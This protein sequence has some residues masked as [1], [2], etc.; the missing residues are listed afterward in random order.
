MRRTG[1]DFRVDLR[2]TIKATMCPEIN[3]CENYGPVPKTEPMPFIN[4][5]VSKLR[6]D[7]GESVMERR[8]GEAGRV[9]LM[10]AP[11]LDPKPSLSKHYVA[12]HASSRLRVFG[13]LKAAVSGRHF[14]MIQWGRGLRYVVITIHQ[15][16][17]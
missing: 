9:F 15:S 12:Q 14:E 3:R 1:R 11:A 2:A 5:R 13:D 10:A 6:V 8:S 4:G 16:G 17:R 7:H